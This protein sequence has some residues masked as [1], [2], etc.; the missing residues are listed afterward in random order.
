M[1]YPGS[2]T[3]A[4]Q[5]QFRLFQ[6]PD[7]VEYPHFDTDDLWHDRAFILV[8][9]FPKLPAP[10][11][12]PQPLS[13]AE[14]VLGDGA[15]P[16]STPAA[17]AAGAPTSAGRLSTRCRLFFWI[18]ESFVP[19]DEELKLLAPHEDGAPPSASSGAE[20]Q[21][22]LKRWADAA[23]RSFWA[24]HGTDFCSAWEEIVEVEVEMEGEESDD[25]W[26]CFNEG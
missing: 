15:A 25:F 7:W 14:T 16:S 3:P 24:Q 5:P 21:A 2:P 10:P 4:A 1:T 11:P 22:L 26:A 13:Q 6:H 8:Q 19:P 9:S 17:A 12:Q 23:A 20:A 18:G